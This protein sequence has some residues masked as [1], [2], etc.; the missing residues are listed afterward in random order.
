MTELFDELASLLARGGYVMFPLIV[1]S[2]VSLT[3]VIERIIFWVSVN[4]RASLRRIARLTRALREGRRDAVE[5]LIDGDSTPYG[6]LARRMYFEGASDAVA[7]EAVE[8][9][10]HRLNRF[11][12][13]LSTI[14]TAAPLLGILGTV[15][16]IIQSF[17]LL[18]DKA[19]LTDPTAVAGG[20][21]A[22]LLTTAFGLVVA[23]VTLFPYMAFKGQVGLA[24]GRI[25]AMVA[26]AQE[27]LGTT[28][29]EA[30]C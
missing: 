15:V 21:A 6:R 3:L 26:A 14:I 17:E 9:E 13:T 24:L 2:V 27:G 10:R 5:E 20:I 8:D 11:M 18:G 25:E 1:L 4:G 16:G 7:M 28:K 22:A 23:L 30:P 12:V 29:D 19:T